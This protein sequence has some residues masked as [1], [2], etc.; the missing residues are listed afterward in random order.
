MHMKKKYKEIVNSIVEE[1]LDV[2]E[3]MYFRGEG[4]LWVIVQFEIY[5]LK[6]AVETNINYFGQKLYI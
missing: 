6:N 3:N 5:C 2:I 1:Y 4:Q